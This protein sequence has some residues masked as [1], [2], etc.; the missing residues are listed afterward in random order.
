MDFISVFKNGAEERNLLDRMAMMMT[1][2]S[3]K[4]YRYYVG[5]T[6]FDFGQD[7]QW[8]T[9]L[10][11]SGVSGGYQALSPVMQ[12]KV[13]MSDGSFKALAVLADEVFESK[14]CPDRIQ[15]GME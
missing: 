12:E 3:P 10:C 2:K 1:L 7:W 14:F 9:V 15:R 8:T 4:R 6:Y 5:E 13:C 11:R